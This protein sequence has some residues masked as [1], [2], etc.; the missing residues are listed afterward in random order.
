M[1]RAAVGLADLCTGFAVL[2]RG[3]DGVDV[4]VA[5][6]KTGEPLA[7]DARRAVRQRC[8][9]RS[10][11]PVAVPRRRLPTPTKVRRP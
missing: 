3:D 6:T 2:R 5:D 8:P 1:L 4:A 11:Y 9:Q 7:F 10:E